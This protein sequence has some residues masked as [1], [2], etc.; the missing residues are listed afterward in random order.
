MCITFQED[1]NSVAE[2]HH[3]CAA[4]APAPDKYFDAAPDPILLFTKP[5]L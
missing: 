1:L 5:T 3:F 2:P 4:P